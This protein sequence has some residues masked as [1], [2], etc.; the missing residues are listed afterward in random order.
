M[1]IRDVASLGPSLS[2][3]RP[4]VVADGGA[5]P[6][7]RADLGGPVPTELGGKPSY[8]TRLQAMLVAT[9]SESISLA[10]K[11]AEHLEGEVLVKMKP[12]QSVGSIE[13]FAA[14]YGAR[15][16]ERIDVPPSMMQAFGGDLVRMV[17]PEG[18]NTAQGIAVLSKDVRVNYACA[19]DVLKHLD[20]G[21]QLIPNDLDPKLW[22]LHNTGQEN[23]TPNADI[24]APE[25]W[26]I[27][28]GQRE[29]GP[30]IAVVD[31]GINYGHN[32]LRANVW[33][34]PGEI[35]GDGID[36]DGNGVIDDVHGYNAING[37]GDP[38]D[39]HSHG[40][41]CMGTVAAEGNNS[42]GVVGVNWQARVMGAKFLSAQ[43]S[44]ST[45]DAIKA[46]L[47]STRM[48]ARITS[49][50]WGGGA[51]NQALY[52]ALK[53]SPALHIFAA[54]NSSNDNDKRA[55]YP[56]SYN[57][58]NIVAVAATDKNDRMAGFSNWGRTS[59][60]LGAPGVNIYS[61]V[62]GQDYKLFSGTSMATPHVAG[63]A[64]LIATAYPG[65]S[66]AEIKARLMNGADK[67]PALNGKCVTGGRLNAFSSLDNDTVAPAAPEDLRPAQVGA[68]AV[69]LTWT[70][71]G[72][73]GLEKRASG[74]LLKVSEQPIT[75]EASFLAARTV[76]TG[77]PSEPGTAERVTVGLIPSS[78]ERTL[79]YG[80]K[81]IDNV[82][83][84]SPLVT[85]ETA[86][87]AARVAFE[88]RMEGDASAW[89]PTGLWG[90][91]E[92]EG[93]GRVWTDSPDIPYQ[94]D[95]NTTLSS[96]S[97]SLAGIQGATL[98]FDARY[99]IE[100]GF[101]FLNVEVS[102]NGRDW[103]TIGRLTGSR[104]WHTQ[105]MDLSNYD[106]KDVRIRF[107]M[108]ADG[109]INA[110]GFYLDNVVVAGDPKPTPP[111]G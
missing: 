83:N 13:D 45:A 16:I 1:T 21:G 77:T 32:D 91:V 18:I 76:P 70:A 84:S 38:N 5:L 48:G 110:D 12:G 104:E 8:T 68:K 37:T 19:N 105:Q 59:V 14:E 2:R 7:D 44:G 53:A 62:L 96:R 71:T 101:D 90:R 42:L 64:G 63:V 60:D 6:Q 51:Y 28:T 106:G 87:P 82:G 80:L 92:W 11:L 29:G 93:N 88:D 72:D 85:G 75:D 39:D 73:D 17:M 9:E 10:P 35:P 3:P 98:L 15:V 100:S 111:E 79:Y 41:H 50:S 34:N 95:S 66:N 108:H 33:V 65:A 56:S 40:S 31:T 94:N 22:G 89:T 26:N 55:S 49:N 58:D 52:D 4:A 99:E 78:S 36:N 107:R 74:Y 23:G 20:E 109:S 25:A 103:T 27:T 97:I 43:G 86:V 61:T 54:G 46:I 24:N 102:E 67:V 30:V 57:L 69:S 81:V 47:Y